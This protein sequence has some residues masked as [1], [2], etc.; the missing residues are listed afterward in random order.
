MGLEELEKSP[1]GIQ[2]KKLTYHLATYLRV[3]L[4]VFL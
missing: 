1:P 2:K 3:G 4:S